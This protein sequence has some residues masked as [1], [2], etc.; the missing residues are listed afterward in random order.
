M[1]TLNGH[2]YYK[3]I[4]LNY[5]HT[6]TNQNKYCGSGTNLLIDV[7]N[8]IQKITNITFRFYKYAINYKMQ[9]QFVEVQ[10]LYMTTS[11]NVAVISCLLA[12]LSPHML[13]VI[14]QM[15]HQP[16][17]IAHSKLTQ[18]P[19]RVEISFRLCPP[20]TCIKPCHPCN[21]HAQYF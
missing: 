17:S 9:I 4:Y 7:V 5:E 2:V 3:T 12:I 10:T 13:S 18:D 14:S 20:Q 1:I 19:H 21:I 8:E 16:P 15:D 11:C 6:Q